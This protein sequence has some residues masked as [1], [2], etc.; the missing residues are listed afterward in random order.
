ML[1]M[2]SELMAVVQAIICSGNLLLDAQLLFI[3]FNFTQHKKMLN[4][5]LQ[6][7]RFPENFTI[8]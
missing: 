5:I 1:L 6:L 2:N 4:Q 8:G 3:T 7:E